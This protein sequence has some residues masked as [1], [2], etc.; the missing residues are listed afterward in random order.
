MSEQSNDIPRIIQV[1]RAQ[2]AA[3]MAEDTA[4]MVTM[5][6]R[7]YEI[8]QAING[9]MLALA[10]EIDEMRRD[11]EIVSTSKILKMERYRQLEIQARQ[12]YQKYAAFADQNI[13]ARQAKLA[14]RGI[15]DTSEFIDVSLREAGRVDVSFTRLPVSAVENMIAVAGDGTPLRDL[16]IKSYP[17]TIEGI[18][19]SLIR[20]TA[21]GYNPRKTAR[22]M[23]RG[24]GVGL[25]RALVIARTE[26]YRVYRE[27]GT[28]QAKESG[29]VEGWIWRCSRSARTCSACMA[30]DGQRFGLLDDLNDHP[31]GRCQKQWIIS[32]VPEPA[33]ESAE[34]WF[35][36]QDEKTQVAILGSG[37]HENWKNGAFSFS[38]MARVKEDATWGNSV[39]Q[40][41]L[42]E[43]TPGS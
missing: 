14:V 29:I 36:R 17:D 26:Q 27:A 33:Y 40:A 16:L 13:S 22:E 25:D 2:K 9:Q 10:Y 34:D 37:K 8:E 6:Q 39:R 20:A 38:D 12:E 5:A 11:G 43:L 28:R 31:C 3:L 4:Q 35:N 30:M 41:T 42:A 19:N 7:W 18:M 32:E 1:M 15:E 24:F 23:A 21:L